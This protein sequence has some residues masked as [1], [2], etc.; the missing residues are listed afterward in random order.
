[1][2]RLLPVLFSL[3][4][5]AVQGQNDTVEVHRKPFTPRLYWDY[6]KTALSWSNFE[7]KTEFGLEILLFER[8]QLIGEGGTATLKP[9]KAFQNVEY[10]SQGQYFRIGAGYLANLSAKDRIGIGVRYGI[11]N[12]EDEG[13]VSIDF[14]S[15][16]ND[17][18]TSQFNRKD[19]NASWYEIVLNS[20]R[21]VHLNRSNPESILNDIFH[22]GF[23]FRYRVLIEYTDQQ[24]IDIYTIPGYGRTLDKRLPAINLFLKVNLF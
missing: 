5:V 20:E 23:L 8:I 16:L 15:D 10:T 7:T 24:P 9:E 6:G 4:A 1:M 17:V 12:F 13:L 19:L 21:K 22:I 2:K 14:Q 3:I 18:Y 11:S